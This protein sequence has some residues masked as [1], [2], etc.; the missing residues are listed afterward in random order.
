MSTFVQ[1]EA[2]STTTRMSKAQKV[3]ATAKEK[4]KPKVL[5]H[6]TKWQKAVVTPPNL[7]LSPAS[8]LPCFSDV[9][10][11][12]RSSSQATSTAPPV[13]APFNPPKYHPNILRAGLTSRLPVLVTTVSPVSSSGVPHPSLTTYTP[14]DANNKSISSLPLSTQLVALD[15]EPATV[16]ELS[17]LRQTVLWIQHSL[18]VFQTI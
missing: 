4:E 5:H 13:F 2:H 12:T 16:E 18:I 10:K 15:P 11:N 9:V 6:P 8:K 17:L 3:I 14:L 7:K 1:L